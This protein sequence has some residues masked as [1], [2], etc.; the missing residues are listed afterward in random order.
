MIAD[1]A[2]SAPEAAPMA[3]AS[4][5]AGPDPLLVLNQLMGDDRQLRPAYG[6]HLP[7]GHCPGCRQVRAVI[8]DLVVLNN[9]TLSPALEDFLHLE[10]SPREAW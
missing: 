10:R 7:E 6:D 8:K 9:M 1:A 5:S 2:A 4:Y 3:A